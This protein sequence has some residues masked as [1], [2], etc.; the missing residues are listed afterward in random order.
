M[1]N[2]LKLLNIKN[3]ILLVFLIPTTLLMGLIATQIFKAQERADHAQASQEAVELFHLFDNI[4]HQFAVERGLTAG[5]VASKGQ[6]P[7]VTALKQQRVKADQAYQSLLAFAPQVL[8]KQLID[9]LSQD[10][11]QQLEQR[12]SIRQQVDT[13]NI[14]DSPFAF[15]SNINRMALDNLSVILTQV[16]APKLEQQLRGLHALL[17]MKEEA[18]KARGALNGA[19]AGQ[20][21]TL[22][23]YANITSYIATEAYALRQATLLFSAEQAH[24]LS[25]MTNSS[26]WRDV[27]AIQ[28]DYLSQKTTLDNLQG[29]SASLWF[30]LAT[31]R[32]GQIKS[33]ADSIANDMTALALQNQQQAQQLVY[34]YI[35]LTLFVVLPLS[36]IAFMSTNRL[37]RRVSRFV[38]QIDTIARSKDLSL[39]LPCEQKDELG[40][41]AHHFNQLTDSFASALQTSLDVAQKTEQE[42]AEMSRLVA[43]TQTVSQQTHLRCDNIATAMT[44]MAQTSQEM[45]GITVEAQQSADSAQNDAMQCQSHGEHSLSTTTKLISSVDDTYTCLEQLEVKM[46]N[47]SEI[48][49][50]INAISEQTNLLALNAAIEAARAGEQGRGFAVVADEVRS[51]AQRS[52]ESTEVIRNLLDD[53]SSNAKT[54]FENM[55]QSR[56]ASYSAQSMVSETN[57]MI[58]TLIGTTKKITDYNSSIATATEEQ[59]QTTQSVESDID[60]LLSMVEETDSNIQKMNKEMHIVKQRME[61]LVSE[62]SLFKLNT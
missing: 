38:E 24:Q 60:N 19:F 20:R 21:S 22:D 3:T 52:K 55:Q 33:M 37:H 57:A 46:A 17:A 43:S 7:Q 1:P 11:R 29:P 13:L 26:N 41:I 31:K 36:I 10:V 54:S 62:V 40:N 56:D 48:L 50:N 51:L 4:A 9:R 25:A 16:D 5:V 61:E 47:V 49:D 32:I 15:Y 34:A 12:N 14:K 35:A 59:A 8:D 42:M 30:E 45:A 27:N 58:E 18:G 44:E 6:G 23:A 2:L 53:I 28:Q 39:K